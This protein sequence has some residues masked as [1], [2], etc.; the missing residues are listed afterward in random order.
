MSDNSPQPGWYDDPRDPTLLRFWDGRAWTHDTMARTDLDA[1]VPVETESA[2][3]VR[4]RFRAKL[5]QDREQRRREQLLAAAHQTKQRTDH[6]RALE[7]Q[8]T[9][10]EDAARRKAIV[11]EEQSRTQMLTTAR[12]L[13]GTRLEKYALSMLEQA[14]VEGRVR[15]GAGF[16][17]VVK[18]EGFFSQ[19]ARKEAL[20]K[21]STGVSITVFSDRIFHGKNVYAV[22]EF[23]NAQVYLDG[24]EQITQR[25]TLTRMALLSPLPGTALIPGLALQKKKKNDLRHAEFLVGG[26]EWSINTPINPDNLQEPR[27]IAQMI[28]SNADAI[29][30]SIERTLATPEMPP[31]PSDDVIGQLE[32]LHALRTQG[33][34]SEAEFEQMKAAILSRENTS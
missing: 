12:S 8:L 28:N 15:I 11:E 23:T 16:I 10:V 29:T 13:G 1:P 31:A 3:G 14:E 22:D 18:A 30:R 17:G 6:Q 26:L 27:R 2:D 21:V 25:P 20:S 19:Y 4:G 32:R 33:V 24:V 5:Q 34:L 9:Q 7:E